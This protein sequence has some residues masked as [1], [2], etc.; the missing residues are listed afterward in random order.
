MLF[1]V[2]SRWRRGEDM[3]NVEDIK[4]VFEDVKYLRSLRERAYQLL[5]EV[6]VPKSVYEILERESDP[7]VRAM[8]V[9][10]ELEKAYERKGLKSLFDFLR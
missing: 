5:E 7:V 3:R 2:L 8:K 4:A 9:L 6:K 10:M 1:D